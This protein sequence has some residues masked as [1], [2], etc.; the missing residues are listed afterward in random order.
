M[1]NLIVKELETLYPDKIVNH[2]EYARLARLHNVTRSYVSGI[3]NENGFTVLTKSSKSNTE[4]RYCKEDGCEV[5]LVVPTSRYCEDHK[6]LTLECYYCKNKVKKSRSEMKRR[7]T[8]DRYSD[9]VFCDRTCFTS[10][11]KKIK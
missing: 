3:A 9:R 8:S 7:S 10:S 11:I 6:D 2:G 4:L 1:T 5:M